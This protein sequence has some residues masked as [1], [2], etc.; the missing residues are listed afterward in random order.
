MNIKNIRPDVIIFDDIQTRECA[1]SEKQSAALLTWM[2]G[3]AMKAKSPFGCMFLF[4]ANMYPTPYS[5][6]KKLK[7]NPN[8]IKFIVGG[9]LTDGSSLWE[10]IQPIKQLIAEY[11]NDKSAGH[12]EIF[13]AEVL[14]DEHAAVNNL[15]DFGTLPT[16]PYIDGD[17]H[18]G[19]FIIID[20]ATDKSNSDLVSI[21]Y[22]EVHDTKPVLMHLK[23]GRLSPSDT[24]RESLQF[25]LN[26]N[27]KLIAVEATAYQ[28]SLLHWFEQVCAQKKITGITII[29]IYPGIRSKNARILSMFKAYMS[30][31]VFVHDKVK[32]I[33][34]AQMSGFNPLKRNNTDGILDLLAYADK[35]L[36]DAIYDITASTII[37]QQEFDA[38][39]LLENT[40]PF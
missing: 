9:I 17:V 28:Y 37:E 40:A 14:N 12:P 8:W 39:A 26:N 4:V 29:P 7:Y 38:I 35:V 16:L 30:G 1:D 32:A 11:E 13:Y 2:F 22:F 27:C 20:P 36:A 15:I 34:H 33:V 21:G 6:L 31:D 5:I 24:I 25:A 3:T 10:E 19:N 18:S 23:E